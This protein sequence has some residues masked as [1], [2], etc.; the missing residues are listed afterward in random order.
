MLQFHRRSW[1]REHANAP[2][3]AAY[4]VVALVLGSQGDAVGA[5]LLG[6]SVALLSSASATAILGAIASGTMA[7]TAIVFSLVLVALQ[8]GGSAYS[9]RVVDILNRNTFLGH[10]LGVFTG[11]F[12][13]ALLAMRT[14]D[15]GGRSGVNISV[16]VVA[17]I[18][19]IASVTVLTLL[20]PQVRTLAI[21][22]VLPALHEDAAVATT[23]VYR[24]LKRDTRHVEHAAPMNLPVSGELTH[25]GPPRYLIGFDVSRLVRCAA[26][27]D[28]V[29]VLPAA[30]GD[31]IITGDR[32]A[33]VLG[34]SKRVDE[35]TLR[36][37]LW[38]EPQRTLDNDPAY[39]IRL[40][41]DIAI[42]ALSPAIND[43]TTAVSVLDEL[44]GVL[45]LLGGSALEDN[46]VLD[47]RGVVR[48]VRA[49]SSWDDLV[50]LALTEIHQYGRESFQVQ[51]RLA[52]MLHDLV[53][54]LPPSR[55]PAL[56]RF[57][58]WRS[59]SQSDLLHGAAGWMDAFALD[60]QG[61][62]HEVPL[63][64]LAH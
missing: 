37:A 2:I 62:G 45:R 13:Y 53:K 44:D 39:S 49:V 35:A 55:H 20:L 50:A 26:E 43:P 46:V 48:L 42:R 9:P 14:V 52:A 28:A 63:D 38:L 59:E 40:L 30:I 36:A 23:R 22:V 51:R 24:P 60:R 1:L 27:A 18:W 15:L 7:L 8:V 25:G 64:E 56:D 10:A 47:E 21:A 32:L 29:I 58:R 19:L 6:T 57:A 17:M 34:A 31:A 4:V 3:T 54:L 33:V 41:V 5:R 12:L 11:T 61:L 16:I